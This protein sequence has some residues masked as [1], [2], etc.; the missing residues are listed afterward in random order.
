MSAIDQINAN[1]QDYDIMSPEVVSDYVEKIG[2]ICKNPNGY[3]KGSLFLARDAQDV[4]RMYKTTANISGGQTIT[5]GTNCTPKKLGDLFNDVDTEVGN[6]KQ[7]LSNYQNYY[8]SKNIL[9]F[10]RLATVNPFVQNN[11]TYTF[12]EDTGIINIVSNGTSSGLTSPYVYL[13]TFDK[14]TDVIVSVE[15]IDST[16]NDYL[17]YDYIAETTLINGTTEQTVTI[18]ANH[19]VGI[20]VRSFSGKTFNEIVKPMIRVCGDNTFVPYVPTNAQLLSYKDNGILG[21]KNLLPNDIVTQTINGVTFTKNS[22]GSISC[23]GTASAAIT[24][25]VSRNNTE[26]ES[27]NYILSGC[28]SGGGYG[29]SYA[30]GAAANNAFVNLGR[31]EGNGINFTYNKSTQNDISIYLWVK[32]GQ[33]M[34]GKVFYPMIRLASDTDPTYQPYAKT[35]T[36]LTKDDSGLIANAFANGAVNLGNNIATSQTITTGGAN[37]TFV[38]NSN[39]E[40]TVNG[41][42]GTALITLK[43]IDDFT[44]LSKVKLSG[45]PS[46]GN[47]TTYGLQIYDV[48]SGTYG[49]SDYG[50]G[51]VAT[52][53][54]THTYE[55]ILFVRTNQTISSKVFKPMITVADMPNSDYNHYV[56]YAMSNKELTE[57]VDGNDYEF[58]Y[59]GAYFHIIKY[60]DYYHCFSN[61]NFGSE[62]SLDAWTTIGSVPNPTNR[63]F[64]GV[65]ITNSG[66]ILKV[67]VKAN[68]DVQLYKVSGTFGSNLYIQC[69]CVLA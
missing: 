31:D 40:V 48:T 32:S 35:N 6:V 50:D 4:E 14:N 57:K 63:D 51:V 47:A 24:L 62:P 58:F 26:L 33:D 42:T 56:P 69:S 2:T 25:Y 34:N 43:V 13:P 9:S 20:S 54:P 22:D 60:G 66:V 11:I 65:L 1:G 45:C 39:K 36:E 10:A 59:N 38:V 53:D 21:A 19:T 8:G 7:A 55:V 64:H 18:P 67:R 52:L 23:S 16:K 5:V 29:T 3:T 15:G 37:L 30:I 28:P 46:G 41:T 61:S 68:G 17:V 44:G 12:H 27:G 49:N